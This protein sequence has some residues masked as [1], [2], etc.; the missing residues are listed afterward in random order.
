MQMAGRSA[1][2]GRIDVQH[3]VHDS[4][5]MISGSFSPQKMLASMVWAFDRDRYGEWARVAIKAADDVT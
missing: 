3:S 2:V 5:L 1:R 4:M